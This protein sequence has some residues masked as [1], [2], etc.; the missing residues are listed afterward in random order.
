[1]S[2]DSPNAVDTDVHQVKPAF[3]T[4]SNELP[5][6]RRASTSNREAAP[7]VNAPYGLS[8]AEINWSRIQQDLESRGYMLRPRYRPGW[9]GSWVGT[10]K[11]PEKCEDSIQLLEPIIVLDAVRIKDGRQV[12]LKLWAQNVRDGSEL[13]VLQYFSDQSRANDPANHCVPLLE[14]LRFEE[15]SDS[16]SLILVEPLFRSWREPPFVMVA[17]GLSF[18]LQALEGLEYMHANNVA[19]GDVHGG[20]ILMDAGSMFPDGFH[21]AFNLNPHH[22]MPEKHLRRLTRLQ[23]PVKYYYIDF[24]SSSMFPSYEERKPVLL[25]AAVWLPPEFE[26]NKDAPLDPFKQDIFALGM[27]LMNEIRYR[28]GLH[29]TLPIL[30]GMI[31][32]KPE[33]RP[34]ATEIKKR[35]EDF[36]TAV[37][38]KRMRRALGWTWASGHTIRERIGD[39]MEYLKVRRD[40]FKYGLPRE[41]FP[42]RT[43]P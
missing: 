1:M 2:S 21:G 22:R 33:D 39:F 43:I 31:E 38:P 9:V 3:P 25:T 13:G 18:I 24:G 15:W 37:E 4:G 36:L 27:T 12:L 7:D 11:R 8:P 41:L 20:N 23:A 30:E 14:T 34:T 6:A 17:E 40:S 42:T 10:N 19:H 35:F 28:P 26:A 32:E 29:F 16:F 5:A